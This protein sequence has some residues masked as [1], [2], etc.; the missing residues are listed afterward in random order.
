[1]A[2]SHDI[3][4]EDVYNHELCDVSFWV[5]SKGGS[6]KYAFFPTCQFHVNAR[7]KHASLIYNPEKEGE[8]IYILSLTP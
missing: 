7:T 3:D 2:S 1:M 5:E 4:D 8:H 6:T